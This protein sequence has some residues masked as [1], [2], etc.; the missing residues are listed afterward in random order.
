[1]NQQP[2]EMNEPKE[3]DVKAELKRAQVNLHNIRIQVQ[4]QEAIVKK[5]Q[6]LA[7]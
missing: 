3:M 6:E 5:F 7:R 1:M 4:I 2:Q